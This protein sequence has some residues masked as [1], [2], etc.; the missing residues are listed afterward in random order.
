LDV[1]IIQKVEKFLEENRGVLR[2]MIELCFDGD[3]SG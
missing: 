1:K 3:H 2:L